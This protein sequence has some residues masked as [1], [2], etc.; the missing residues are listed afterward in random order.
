MPKYFPTNTF[1]M[2]TGSGSGVFALML[3]FTPPRRYHLGFQY[4]INTRTAQEAPGREVN[5]P[6]GLR[7][8]RQI[9]FAAA[10]FIPTYTSTCKK[11]AGRPANF[12]FCSPVQV[13]PPQGSFARVAAFYR[14]NKNLNVYG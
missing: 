7:R 10:F 4:V 13:L 5:A 3:E 12:L 8:R 6:A 1:W 9:F 2:R 14:F 11:F